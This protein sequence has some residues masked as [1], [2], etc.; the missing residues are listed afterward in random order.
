LSSRKKDLINYY[1]D[2]IHN[3]DW[4]AGSINFNDSKLLKQI[5]EELMNLHNPNITLEQIK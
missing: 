5:K 2:K 4:E 3:L 1:I